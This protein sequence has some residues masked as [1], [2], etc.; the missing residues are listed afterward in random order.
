MSNGEIAETQQ[1]QQPIYNLP[2]MTITEGLLKEQIDP[3]TIIDEV[4]NLL[5]GKKLQY[6]TKKNILEWS[7]PDNDLRLINEKG[8]KFLLLHL[9]T[10]LT[11]IF[12]LSY[13]TEQQIEE[14]IIA[15]AR[16]LIEAVFEHWD[17]WEIKKISD[18]STIV[19]ILTDT[20]FATL[21]KASH[22]KYLA[23]LRSVQDFRELQTTQ[24]QPQKE[25]AGFMSKMPIIGR[26]FKR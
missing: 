15:L 13:F 16:C 18:A 23:Y 4:E 2:S 19:S 17:E 21:C 6:D 12:Q 22:G 11:K 1:Q 7:K 14:M 10:R 20:T 25:E 5:L 26:L 3:T 24:F 9:R 8:M